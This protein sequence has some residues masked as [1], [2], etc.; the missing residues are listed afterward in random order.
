MTKTQRDI[1]A[2]IMTHVEAPV[3]HYAI[4]GEG[5][6]VFLGLASSNSGDS[7]M[8]IA[9]QAIHRDLGYNW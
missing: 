1:L 6:G 3:C 8:Y 9:I 7:A 2:D 4:E 5:Y